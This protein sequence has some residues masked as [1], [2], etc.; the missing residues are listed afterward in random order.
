MKTDNFDDIIFNRPKNWVNNNKKQKK[1]VAFDTETLNGYSFLLSDSS[2]N[3]VTCN[4]KGLRIEK[5][6]K[7]NTFNDMMEFLYTYDKTLNVFYNLGYDNDAI[8]KHL[9]IDNLKQYA[10]IGYTVFDGWY[11]SGIPRKSI[12]I[13]RAVKITDYKF[14]SGV[15]RLTFSDGKI[16]DYKKK[17]VF[18]LD[19]DNDRFI[20]SRKVKF[21][22]IYQFF[23]Y[24][25]SA[26]LDNVSNKY[27][28]SQKDNIE[29]FGY[30]KS[31]MPLDN[32]IVAYCHKDCELTKRLCDIVIEA[33]NDI[34]LIFNNPYS[35]ATIS[36]DYFFEF[37]G[38]T[39]PNNFLYQYGKNVSA[40]NKDIMRYAYYAY[41]GGRTEVCKRGNFE[42]AQEYDVNSMYPTKMCELYNIFKCEWIRIITDTEFKNYDINN[43]AYAFLNCNI[44]MYDNYVNPLPHKHNGYYIY[45]HGDFMNYTISL[46]EYQMIIELNLGEVH[47]NNGWIGLKTSDLKGDYPFKNI[48]EK[49]YTKRNSFKKTDFRNSLLK[50][51]LNSIYGRFIE[52]N[53]NKDM[54]DNI[55]LYSD[56]YIIT[57][58]DIYKKGYYAGKYFCPIYACDI[59]AR[60]RCMLYRGIHDNEPEHNFIASFTDS[61]LS[62]EKLKNIDSGNLL[63]QWEHNE[64]ELTI[65]GSGVYRFESEDKD[66]KL[67]TRGIHIK[68]SLNDMFGFQDFSLENI[69][70]YGVN[71]TKVKKLKESLIQ[72]TPEQFNTF[73]EQIKRVN[74]NF[75]KKRNWNYSLKGVNEIYGECDSKSININKIKEYKL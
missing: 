30:T 21:F 64:G 25:N 66:D 16:K 62:K 18:Y 44:K 37:S 12:D 23:K 36:A 59:T 1:S 55:N 71:Q 28:N 31:N 34:G 33:C 75:D 32:I 9:P 5:G 40:K 49:T 8:I 39:N 14:I 60:S 27:L 26:S 68:E 56:D 65:I 58:S 61:I 19:I 29:F 15:H 53:I 73:V 57:E 11:I 35:C 6:I 38:L 70:S 47:I 72:D 41:K 22:D 74:L 52:V 4:T 69:L 10:H 20:V 67:R 43:M 13:A 7:I 45:G 2:K 50:I 24:E 46:S 54:D 51:I 63:G 48:I 42:N 3:F 17:P